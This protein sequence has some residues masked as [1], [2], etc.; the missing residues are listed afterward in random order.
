MLDVDDGRKLV[1]LERD[2]LGD[3]G[4]GLNVMGGGGGLV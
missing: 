1:G 3:P 4:G 2:N